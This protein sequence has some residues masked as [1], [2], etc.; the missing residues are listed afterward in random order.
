MQG[1]TT[2]VSA[3]KS[4][5]NWTMALKKNPDTS[6]LDP[7]LLNILGII[8]QNAHA[9]VRF[10]TTN[11]QSSF[12]ADITIPRYLKDGTISRLRLQALNTL[13]VAALDSSGAKRCHFR[14]STFLHCT[15]LL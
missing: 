15:L 8:L 4:N 11:G 5:T 6:G 14:S 7:S 12:D 10:R 2:H 13:E 3:P 1:V 9:F